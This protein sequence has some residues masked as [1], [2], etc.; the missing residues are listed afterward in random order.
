MTAVEFSQAYIL[1]HILLALPVGAATV[2]LCNCG[3][4]IF[5]NDKEQDQKLK[6]STSRESQLKAV[7]FEKKFLIFSMK[8]IVK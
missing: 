7:N 1:I 8:R 4:V 3:E 2:P 5:P 6:L